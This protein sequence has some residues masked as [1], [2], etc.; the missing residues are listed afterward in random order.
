MY[1]PM[2]PI[3]LPLK[4]T[5]LLLQGDET[6][7]HFSSPPRPQM[8]EALAV[9]APKSPG[10]PGSWISPITPGCREIR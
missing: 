8:L 1:F 3:E 10:S 6:C 5:A 2:E 7:K 9:K 4:H